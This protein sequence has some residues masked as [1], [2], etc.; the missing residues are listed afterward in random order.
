MENNIMRY[1]IRFTKQVYG[2][3]IIEAKNK[4]EAKKKFLDGDI[5]DEY[6]NKSDYIYDE[7]DGEPIFE[8]M[9]N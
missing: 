3:L 4:K 7:K 9:P 5:D 8:E 2:C 1:S 6:D